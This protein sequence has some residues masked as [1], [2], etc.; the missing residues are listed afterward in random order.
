[1]PVEERLLRGAVSSDGAAHQV[2][3]LGFD[4]G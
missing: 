1:M 4:T 3:F 2:R